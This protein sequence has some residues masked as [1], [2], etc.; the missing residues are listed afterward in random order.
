MLKEAK[1]QN[2]NFAYQL[3]LNDNS[4]ITDSARYRGMTQF[5]LWFTRPNII[6]QKSSASTRSELE[7]M[8][9]EVV[10]SV[11]LIHYNSQLAEFWKNGELVNNG[12][13]PLNNNIPEQYKDDPRWFL[14]NTDSY[15]T[16]VWAF[17][18]VKGEAPNREW[19]VY[20]QSPEND[21][22][23]VT[24]NIPEYGNVLVDSKVNGN[25]YVLMKGDIDKKTTL[26]TPE[27][28][29]ISNSTQIQ[30]RCS[31][32]QYGEPI[33]IKSLGIT[34]E[35]QDEH[36]K[37][38]S[39]LNQ[40]G[41]YLFEDI[42]V[43]TNS[44]IVINS[45]IELKLI[46]KN[47][48]LTTDGNHHFRSLIE[49]GPNVKHIEIDGGE[50]DG[51]DIVISGLRFNTSYYIH[52][53]DMHHFASK[54]GDDEYASAIM[55]PFRDQD[56]GC[57]DIS[58]NY[59]HDIYGDNDHI[60][61]N[62]QGASRA[63]TVIWSSSL[64]ENLDIYIL[65]NNISYI[66]GEEGDAIFLL[67]YD[68]ATRN[69][70]SKAL[71]QN[72]IISGCNR[73]MIKGVASNMSIISNEFTSFNF[74][75]EEAI[76]EVGFLA[77]AGDGHNVIVEDNKFINNG[78]MTFFIL[79]F[80]ESNVKIKNNNFYSRRNGG[81]N[82]R[83]ISLVLFEDKGSDNIEFS[84]NT[85]DTDADYQ[86]VIKEQN[87]QNI[88]ISNNKMKINTGN[89][90]FVFLYKPTHKN[91][92]FEENILDAEFGSPTE[93][94]FNAFVQI[95]D[96]SVLDNVKFIR[97]GIINDPNNISNGIFANI[98]GETEQ[99]YIL[100]QDNLIEGMNNIYNISN[101]SNIEFR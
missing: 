74:H 90:K 23:G 26:I 21:M 60:L 33:D 28:S 10:D 83:G 79:V 70:N 41:V 55:S 27:T 49:A 67:D 84:Y 91:I 38:E 14:L 88:L 15:D 48:K 87:T 59:I 89:K 52:D 66:T 58:N 24:V 82:S 37:L 2:P 65:D 34:G 5:T 12:D 44:T 25:F 7:P 93:T 96:G 43:I 85:I 31:I 99:K 75:D 45:N 17:A 22:S 98:S 80:S 42:T 9:K 69:L 20:T 56:S 94:T 51:K 18:I 95:N 6:R 81:P 30:S 62:A 46:F 19:L 54:I 63:V 35:G 71:I 57:I 50:F 13:S 72:N 73:R 53:T 78:G 61:T 32:P 101:T 16:K 68:T 3:S 47:S 29:D 64:I 8:F 39:I 36:D 11:E 77:I 100:F 1:S 86:I 97:N 76:N 40:G 4:K 92:I